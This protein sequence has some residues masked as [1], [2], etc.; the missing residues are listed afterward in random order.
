MRV[1]PTPR[2]RHRPAWPL[3]DRRCPSLAMRRQTRLRPP[4]MTFGRHV[5]RHLTRAV[6]RLIQEL[7]VHQPQELRFT[8]VS[9]ADRRKKR[10]PLIDT[11]SH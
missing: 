11:R 5:P 7:R 6:P 1:Y 9:P 10:G 3:A 4:Q 2:M 8:S